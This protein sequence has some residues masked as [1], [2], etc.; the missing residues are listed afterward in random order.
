L[1]KRVGGELRGRRIMS[2]LRLA[3]HA[4]SALTSNS[5]NAIEHDGAANAFVAG[6]S[7]FLRSVGGVRALL[8]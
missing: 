8:C 3:S 2:R 1:E 7:H 6:G 5:P 4:S